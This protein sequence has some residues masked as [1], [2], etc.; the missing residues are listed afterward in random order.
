MLDTDDVRKL[1][2][3]YAGSTES[4]VYGNRKCETVE[5]VSILSAQCRFQELVIANAIF[6]NNF[7]IKLT[8]TILSNNSRNLLQHVLA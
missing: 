7:Y 8:E 2:S 3:E 1:H 4:T 6:W 5:N